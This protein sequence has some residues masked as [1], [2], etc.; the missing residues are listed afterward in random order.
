MARS[1]PASFN[2]RKRETEK[3]AKR[4]AKRELRAQRKAKKAQRPRQTVEGQYGNPVIILSRRLEASAD[5]RATWQR[6]FDAGIIAALGPTAESRVDDDAILHFRL[7][8]QKACQGTLSLA[9][10]AD[11]IDVQ[12]KLTAYP[13]KLEEIRRV[14]RS[15]VSEAT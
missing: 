1:G 8:K 9:G 12:V 3:K 15:L 10:E 11:T 13:A 4:D 6:W 5:L 7:N 2:K 14:A